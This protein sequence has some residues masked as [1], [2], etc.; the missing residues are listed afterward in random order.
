MSKR[1]LIKT[2]LGV[3]EA[4]SGSNLRTTLLENGVPLYNGKSATFNCNG[5]GTCG[6]CAVQVKA[7]DGSSPKSMPRLTAEELRLKL[8]PHFNKNENIR[9]ACQCSVNEDVVVEK[10]EGF[11][12]HKYDSNKKW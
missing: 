11:C 3:I 4:T 2:S 1:V 12:G 6:T 10:F 7:L 5:L 8:P 9:L